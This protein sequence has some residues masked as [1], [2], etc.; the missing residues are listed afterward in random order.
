MVLLGS[1]SVV[2]LSAPVSLISCIEIRTSVK[3]GLHVCKRLPKISLL[4]LQSKE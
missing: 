2:F 1:P 3:W 4:S